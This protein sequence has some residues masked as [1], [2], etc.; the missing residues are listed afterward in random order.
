MHSTV[1]HWIRVGGLATLAMIGATAARAQVVGDS[2][3]QTAGD[4]LRPSGVAPRP[5]SVSGD[6][7]APSAAPPLPATASPAPP[8]PA[9]PVQPGDTTLQRACK[10]MAPGALAPGLLAVVFRTGTTKPEA[11]E[12]ARA[13]GG[14]IV[15]MSE[16]G[17]V[18]VEVPAST[19]PLPV[20]ADQLIRQNPVTQVTPT[21]C[22]SAPASPAA[23]AAAPAAAPSGA[24]PATPD[25]SARPR[26]ST[27][28]PAVRPGP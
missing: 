12:A 17:E 13:V 20:A 6:T 23:P 7:T 24:A 10:G 18:Y 15:G 3:A 8:A 14:T 11:I 22:P 19:A 9:A 16:K 21:R 26:D 2:V 28:A 1:G 5:D 25:T 4:T 27:Q